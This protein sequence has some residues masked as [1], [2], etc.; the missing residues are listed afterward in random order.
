[1]IRVRTFCLKN[2]KQA[3][4]TG[5]FEETIAQ[6]FLLLFG[7]LV[8]QSNLDNLCK[9]SLGECQYSAKMRK[10][11]T[12]STPVVKFAFKSHFRDLD[13]RIISNHCSPP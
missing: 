8:L 11:S 12:F 5:Y 4:V 1:M 10:R 6:I 13:F 7:K 2:L 3:I 9:K